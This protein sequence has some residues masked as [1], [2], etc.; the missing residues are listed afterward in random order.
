MLSVIYYISN[1][2]NILLSLLYDV[3]FYRNDGV[4]GRFLCTLFR[5]NWVKQ[6]HGIMRRN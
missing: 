3:D 6:T 5:L 1:I 2:T 4:L